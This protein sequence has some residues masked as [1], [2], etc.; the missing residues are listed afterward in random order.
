[1]DTRGFRKEVPS[2]DC[3]FLLQMVIDQ[4]KKTNSSHLLIAGDVY[5][6]NR[7][8]PKVINKTNSILGLL[9]PS[10]VAFV[11]GNHDK[12]QEEAWLDG[13]EG[14]IHLHPEEP[15]VI[16][17][18]KIYGSDYCSGEEFG[19]MLGCVPKD[20]TDFICHQAIK[21]GLS[22]EGAW[23]TQMDSFP[24]HI[25][26][27]WIGDLHMP[28]ELFNKD[29][30]VRAV[31]PGSL[32]PRKIN[33]VKS[34]AS[35]IL[36][37]EELDKNGFFKYQK[38]DIPARPVLKKYIKTEEDLI[39]L[40]DNPDFIREIS[41]TT[42]RDRGIPEELAQP[43]IYLQYTNDIRSVEQRIQEVLDSCGGG[44]IVPNIEPSER[45]I[46]GGSIVSVDFDGENKTLPDLIQRETGD[47][48]DLRDF[49]LDLAVAP[50]SADISV[51]I[52]NWREKVLDA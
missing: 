10:Q 3:Y 37:S 44:Y 18:H 52:E 24:E 11:Q 36:V 23:N 25:K 38:I 33:E 48:N 5:D 15:L 2:D 43:V 46:V 31:Y 20:A 30:T 45:S 34:N 39:D 49:S 21:E 9:D 4:V 29:K 13:L 6:K 35:V 47:N 19:R 16:G 28:M 40:L 41:V 27:V 42:Y 26:N 14:S 12:H 51:V 22:F 17:D 50:S 8:I 32:W 7:P 1:M